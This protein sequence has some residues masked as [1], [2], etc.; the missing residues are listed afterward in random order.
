MRLRIIGHP[1]LRRLRCG[2]SRPGRLAADSRHCQ[3]RTVATLRVCHPDAVRSLWDG[4][5]HEEAPEIEGGGAELEKGF[6]LA[7]TAWRFPA[8]AAAKLPS[9]SSG[10]VSGHGAR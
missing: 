5:K 6:E 9:I 3:P 8:E 1:S 10:L 7:E 4:C 2:S